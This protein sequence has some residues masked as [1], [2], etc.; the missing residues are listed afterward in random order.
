MVKK[1]YVEVGYSIISENV[2]NILKDNGFVVG[3]K[4]FKLKDS[5]IKRIRV[6]LKTD[7]SIA[8]AKRIS[9]P[10]RRIYK[11]YEA[12]KPVRNGFGIGIVSTSAGIMTTLEAKKRH[13]GGEVLCE[14]Y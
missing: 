5:V 4:V 6:D 1:P 8:V 14:V 9:K 7:S 10:G 2:L 3:V 12:L 11:N 13:L